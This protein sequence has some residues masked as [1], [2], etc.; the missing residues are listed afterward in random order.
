M[1]NPI[2]EADGDGVKRLPIYPSLNRMDTFANNDQLPHDEMPKLERR[3]TFA[4]TMTFNPQTFNPVVYEGYVVQSVRKTMTNIG[5]LLDPDA[6]Y[7]NALLQEYHKHDMGNEGDL[8]LQTGFAR[9]AKFWR[10]FLLICLLASFMSLVAAGF[11]NLTQEVRLH[12]RVV[13]MQET[14]Q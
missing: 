6:V 8:P 11:V 1:S 4:R 2:H 9:K 5:E 13:Y 7:T 14:Q 12:R 3:S 10:V